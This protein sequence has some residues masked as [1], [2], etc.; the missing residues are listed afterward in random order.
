MATPRAGDALR[1]A[2]DVDESNLPA[3]RRKRRRA[4]LARIVPAEAGA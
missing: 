1:G 4:G 2:A 3:V